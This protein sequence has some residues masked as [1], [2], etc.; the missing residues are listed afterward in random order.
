MKTTS[1]GHGAPQKTLS[2]AQLTAELAKTHNDA[3]IADGQRPAARE[4]TRELLAV[5]RAG[6]GSYRGAVNPLLGGAL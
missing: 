3:T 2:V 5:A 1:K 4:W 6:S